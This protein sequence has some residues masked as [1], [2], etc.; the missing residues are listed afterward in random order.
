MTRFSSL[1]A[2]AMLAALLAAP[3]SAQTSSQG[4]SDCA[5]IADNAERLACF[6]RYTR[7]AE[8][9]PLATPA[10]APR[11]D[12]VP[13]AVTAPVADAPSGAADAIV[14]RSQTPALPSETILD[15]GR[16][17]EGTFAV[18]AIREVGRGQFL[19]LLN[20][21]QAWRQTQGEL[22]RFPESAAGLS[23][24]LTSGLFGSHRLTLEDARGKQYARSVLVK[25]L[26]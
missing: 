23:A 9:A 26:R 25:R 8:A 15:D 5:A 14:E 11:P 3:A 21:G 12:P 20:N 19:V 1:A 6:D 17:T 13:P 18:R 24:K 4:I 10:P 2:T 16:R 22:R 7:P